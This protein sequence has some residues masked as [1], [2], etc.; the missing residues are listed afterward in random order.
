MEQKYHK[1]DRVRFSALELEVMNNISDKNGNNILPE[2]KEFIFKKYDAIFGIIDPYLDKPLYKQISDILIKPAYT[3]GAHPVE[4]NPFISK[5]MAL[6]Y[7]MNSPDKI[8]E[9]EFEERFRRYDGTH[10]V[11]VNIYQRAA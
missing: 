7:A 5:H 11:L 9:S 2:E 10:L 6:E 4:V 1:D 8:S 3:K